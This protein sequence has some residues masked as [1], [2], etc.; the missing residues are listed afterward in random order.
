M[1]P[2]AS[3]VLQS[4][5]SFNGAAP[6]RERNDSGA[7][8]A[9][10][11]SQG[12]NGAAPFRERNVDPGTDLYLVPYAS[13]EPLPFESGMHRRRTFIL[14]CRASFNVAAPFRERNGK[15]FRGTPES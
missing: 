6:F 7:C 2:T 10:Y 11:A 13:M 3:R 8:A 4:T 12:F 5:V 9:Q 15:V 1:E 14:V